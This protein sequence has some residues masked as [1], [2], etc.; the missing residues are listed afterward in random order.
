MGIF[1]F[2]KPDELK[3]KEKEYER[4]IKEHVRNVNK[5]YEINKDMLRT[6]CDDNSVLKIVEDQITQHDLSKYTEEEF[7]AYRNKFY[8]LKNE[9]IDDI[10]FDHAWLHHIHNNPHHWQY[11][12]L[13][14]DEGNIKYLEMPLNYLFE[15][16]LDWAAM[17]MKFGGTPIEY[18]ED[19]ADHIYLHPNT[20]KLLLKIL[21]LLKLE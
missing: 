14:E 13:I 16:C 5:A 8:N 18:Y 15:L 6:F 19:N 2:K 1:D 9:P 17:S 3:L 11:W 7:D 12:V 20:K 21:P 10:A 4:Y